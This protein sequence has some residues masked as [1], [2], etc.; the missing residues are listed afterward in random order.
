M[1][2]DAATVYRV[3][4]AFPGDAP[5]IQDA[6]LEIVGDAVRVGP[7]VGSRRNAV[8]LGDAAVTPGLVNAHCHLDLAFAA[9]R[10][11]PPRPAGSLAAW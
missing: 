10:P 8:D 11:P 6:L 3:R 9:G 2:P 5:P 4:W 7:W 1:T